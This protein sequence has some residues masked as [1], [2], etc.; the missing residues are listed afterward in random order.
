MKVPILLPNIFNHPF[1]YESSNLD[2]KIGDYVTVPFGRYKITGVENT[3]PSTKEIFNLIM[4]LEIGLS[5]T[6]SNSS[7]F[8]SNGG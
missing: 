4:N 6:S 1:T 5:M 3:T 2:L 7:P 8:I